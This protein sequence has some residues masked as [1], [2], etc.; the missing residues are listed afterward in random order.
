MTAL[1][2]LAAEND[3]IVVPMMIAG[4]TDSHYFRQKG[5]DCYG[6]VPIE[7]TPGRDSGSPRRQRADLGQG[8][9]R[10]YPADGRTAEIHWDAR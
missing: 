5:L 6:F 2:K 8:T 1:G 9:R 10:G 3:T 7:E 4:F